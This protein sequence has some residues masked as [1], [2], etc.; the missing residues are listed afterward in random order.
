[1]SNWKV[2]TTGVRFGGETFGKNL[3]QL[4]IPKIAEHEKERA[5]LK[6]GNQAREQRDYER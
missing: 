4:Q 1:M 5:D 2:D 3:Q 6:Y